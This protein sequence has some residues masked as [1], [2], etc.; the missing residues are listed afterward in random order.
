MR[1]LHVGIMLGGIV[2]IGTGFCV[3]RKYLEVPGA[4]AG[5]TLGYSASVVGDVDGDGFDDFIVGAPGHR[6]T[7]YGSWGQALLFSGK[8]G[9][10][11]WSWEGNNDIYFVGNSVAGGGDITGDGVPDL[12]VGAGRRGFY[13]GAAGVFI[14]SGATKQFIWSGSEWAGDVAVAIV[15]DQDGD[16]LRDVVYAFPESGEDQ[17][18][19]WI[20]SGKNGRWLGDSFGDPGESMGGSVSDAGDFDGDGV[21]DFIVGSNDYA[22]RS[23]FGKVRVGSIARGGWFWSVEKDVKGFGASVCGLGDVNGDGYSDVAVAAPNKVYVYAGPSGTLLWE[24]AVVG[25]GPVVCGVGDINGDGV[26]DLAV[27]SP[28]FVD[29]TGKKVGRVDVLSGSS[30]RILGTKNGERAGDAFGFAVAAGGD[31]NADG[32]ADVVVGA[33]GHD[34]PAGVNTGKAYGFLGGSR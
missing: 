21:G 20:R 2:V 3:G 6:F 13:G 14:Y 19:V 27:G 33:P 7:K 34:G 31:L 12:V 5:D 15:G 29:S 8:T 25:K 22:G 32:S 30:G 28:D 1:L 9:G 23:P 16:G 18:R 4:L 11:L 26:R 10:V 17:G 24:Q